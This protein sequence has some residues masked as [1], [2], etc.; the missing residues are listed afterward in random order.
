MF[1][2]IIFYQGVSTDVNSVRKL[3]PRD[4]K[5]LCGIV[6]PIFQRGAVIV[7]LRTSLNQT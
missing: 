5:P 1:L 6:I 3:F 4:R 7:F 2:Y